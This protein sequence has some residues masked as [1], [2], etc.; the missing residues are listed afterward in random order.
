MKLGKVWNVSQ[1]SS[2]VRARLSRPAAQM[3]SGRPISSASA[4]AVATV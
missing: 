1:A 3:P 4:T 2:T